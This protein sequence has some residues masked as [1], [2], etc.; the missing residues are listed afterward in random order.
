MAPYCTHP[1][2]ARRRAKRGALTMTDML[3]FTISGETVHGKRLGTELGYPTANLQY[4]PVPALPPNGVYVALAQ[5]DG[6]RYV[7]ILNQGHHPTVPEGQP[8]I[9]THMLGYAGGDLY[10][11]HLTLTY[12]RYLRPERRFATL[13]ALQHQLAEDVTEAADWALRHG[14]LTAAGTQPANGAPGEAA[15]NA[16]KQA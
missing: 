3:P 13:E 7:A 16:A 8:T 10:H 2:R 15:A 11:R 12:L 14:L 6:Q 5:V 9:E 4:P 1:T